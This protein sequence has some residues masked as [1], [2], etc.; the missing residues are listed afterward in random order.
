MS[1]SNE[2]P[3][4]HFSV[5]LWC[6]SLVSLSGVTLCITLQC[7]YL[8]SLSIVTLCCHSLVSLFSVT[9]WCHSVV[10]FSEVTLHCHYLMSLSIVTHWR[11]SLVSFYG[12]TL[13][14]KVNNAKIS[15]VTNCNLIIRFNIT[16]SDDG[17]RGGGRD[18]PFL[19]KR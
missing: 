9:L 6:Y 13:R 3:Y 17:G 14:L 1:L 10:S 15:L 18:G 8:M 11:H 2:T 4:F 19:A 7:H 12:V 16:I 5:T